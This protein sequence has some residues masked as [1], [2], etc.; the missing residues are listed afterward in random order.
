[1]EEVIVNVLTIVFGLGFIGTTFWAVSER[2]SRKAK[3]GSKNIGLTADQLAE[4]LER[5]GAPKLS[6]AVKE[7]ADPFHEFSEFAAVVETA[8]ADKKFTKEE[9]LNMWNEGKDVFIE[10]KDFVVKILKKK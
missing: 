5:H 2:I 6:N 4:V 3:S 1:M 7:A 8:T 10:G 9:I